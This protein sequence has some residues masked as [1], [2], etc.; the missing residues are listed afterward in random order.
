MSKFRYVK[1]SAPPV[2]GQSCRAFPQECFSRKYRLFLKISLRNKES[3]RPTRQHN[4]KFN[5]H[6]HIMNENALNPKYIVLF[7]FNGVYH[8]AS[9]DHIAYSRKN[10]SGY[11]YT[12]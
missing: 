4:N 12:S 5:I 11:V 10:T 6:A 2:L 8:T 1:G 3:S 9:E 7:I